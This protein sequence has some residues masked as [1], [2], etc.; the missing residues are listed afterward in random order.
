MEGKKKNGQGEGVFLHDARST[1][2]RKRKKGS[3]LL[4]FT[5]QVCVSTFRTP[6]ES[7]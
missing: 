5:Y 1:V 2:R 4:N 3:W 6:F 7:F